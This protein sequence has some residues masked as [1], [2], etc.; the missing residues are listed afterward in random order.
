MFL[1]SFF[2]SEEP[3]SLIFLICMYLFNHSNC[4]DAVFIST[5]SSMYGY[6]FLP[7]RYQRVWQLCYVDTH[8]APGYASMPSPSSY[9]LGCDSQLWDT[10][11]ASLLPSSIP[12]W[13][14]Y[15]FCLVHLLALRLNYLEREKEENTVYPHPTP[16]F[17]R[18]IWY[19][20][21]SCIWKCTTWWVL[22]MKS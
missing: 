15:P 18:H 1:T 4:M 21:N 14:G 6:L 17:L 19:A 5:V 16:A 7:L 11:D 13:C 9:C 22:I 2:N 12:F 10:A 3:G 20:K 8:T